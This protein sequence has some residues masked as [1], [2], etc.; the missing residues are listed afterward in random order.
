MTHFH[1]SILA[2]SKDTLFKVIVGV[3]KKILL[4]LMRFDA[5]NK[6]KEHTKGVTFVFS[7]YAKNVH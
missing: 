5:L 7:L 3:E 2:L 4:W 6:K 1:R